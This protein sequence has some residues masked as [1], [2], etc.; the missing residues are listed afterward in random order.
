MP[1]LIR[2]WDSVLPT[3]VRY[4]SCLVE[5]FAGDEKRDVVGHQGM[6][7]MGGG[8]YKKR[9]TRLGSRMLSE[10]E[11]P[12][13]IFEYLTRRHFSPEME[14]LGPEGSLT[15]RRRFWYIFFCQRNGWGT[16]STA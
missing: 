6:M 12:D 7:T 8:L 5:E 3:R 11:T 10:E 9:C 15:W 1:M 13:N 14:S 2:M 4:R 16:S